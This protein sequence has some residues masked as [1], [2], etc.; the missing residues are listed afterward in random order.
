MYQKFFA[1]VKIMAG[2][3]LIFLAFLIIAILTWIEVHSLL[4]NVISSLVGFEYTLAGV[5]RIF[6]LLFGVFAL[7]VVFI[8]S[9]IYLLIGREGNR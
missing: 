7:A 4:P 2:I 5:F 1:K 9:G 3:T 6:A 8:S